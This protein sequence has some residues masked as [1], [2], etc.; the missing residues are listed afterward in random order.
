MLDSMADAL[1]IWVTGAARGIGAAAAQAL[2][3]AHHHVTLSGRNEASLQQLDNMLE[4]GSTIVVPCDVAQQDSVAEAY[5]RATAMFGPVDVLINNAGI[6][7]WRDLVDLSVDDFD[8]Q[9]SVNL[10]GVFLCCKAVLPAMLKNGAGM[11]ININ[12]VASVKAFPGNTA[13]AASKGGALA[14]SRALREE[15]REQGV[16]VTDL[17]VGATETDLWSEKVRSQHRERMMDISD[18]ASTITHLVSTFGNPRTHY[19]EIVLRPQWGDLD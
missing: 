14:L 9:I 7:V 8:D 17:L 19:E 10:R 11:I 5:R 4:G 12:S 15:V 13:Y 18:V 6:G 2:S 16:T 3:S 1:H